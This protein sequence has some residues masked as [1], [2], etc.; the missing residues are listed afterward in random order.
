MRVSVYK[1]GSWDIPYVYYATGQ[2]KCD[3]GLK[4]NYGWLAVKEWKLKGDE[5]VR[6]EGD[7]AE[8]ITENGR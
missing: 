4:W 1:V 2:E 6:R 8:K 7:W 5:W 3:L